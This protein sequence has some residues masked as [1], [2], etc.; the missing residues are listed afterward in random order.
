METDIMGRLLGS[1]FRIRVG[2]DV[3]QSLER[4]FKVHSTFGEELLANLTYERLPKFCYLCG[5][6]GHR[7]V[8]L[9]A[10]EEDFNDPGKETQYGLWLQAPLPS[11]GGF[12]VS[13]FG[14]FN[15]VL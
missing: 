10:F 1:S 11:R 6:L 13:S 3:N 12:Q 5:K 9:G 7:K 8:L 15:P 4:V 14:Y 2:L